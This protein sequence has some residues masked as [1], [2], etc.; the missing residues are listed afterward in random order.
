MLAVAQQQRDAATAV[1]RSL[2]IG[3]LGRVKVLEGTIGGFVMSGTRV[4][5]DRTGSVVEEYNRLIEGGVDVAAALHI[6][7]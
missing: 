2:G 4:V 5:I 3:S 6:T 7:C 1:G